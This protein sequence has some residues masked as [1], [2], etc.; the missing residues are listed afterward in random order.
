MKIF[1]TPNMEIQKFVVEDIMDGSGVFDNE[2]EGDLIP[3]GLELGL[4]D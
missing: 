4:N 1:E 3:D 2:T